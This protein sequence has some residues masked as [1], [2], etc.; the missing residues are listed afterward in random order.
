MKNAKALVASGYGLRIEQQVAI[1]VYFMTSIVG[2]YRADMLVN[3]L[4]IVE[5]KGTTALIPEYEAQLL[6]Y[7]KATP[8]EVGLLVNF[9]PKLE[10]KPKVYDNARKGKLSWTNWTLDPSP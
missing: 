5:F 3:R 9:G 4:V 6:N 2:E 7:L 1:P 10:Y 8:I